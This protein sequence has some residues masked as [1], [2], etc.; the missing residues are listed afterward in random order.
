MAEML[1][2]EQEMTD[3][4]VLAE[5]TGEEQKRWRWSYGI[6]GSHALGCIE[7]LRALAATRR[8]LRDAAA[9]E[10]EAIA[11]MVETAEAGWRR[12][13]QESVDSRDQAYWW[14][15]TNAAAYLTVQIRAR[16]GTDNG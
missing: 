13:R 5:L 3:D 10:R 1:T 7:S 11:A 14:G 4:E 6:F 8:A 9:V 16:R 2:R 15:H 12:M